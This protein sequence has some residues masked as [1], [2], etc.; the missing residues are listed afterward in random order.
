MGKRKGGEEI[1]NS[2]GEKGSR[3]QRRRTKEEEKE[4]D[5]EEEEKKRTVFAPCALSKRHEGIAVF[6]VLDGLLDHFQ[7]GFGR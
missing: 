4:E 5:E 6:Q 3:R 2:N 1:E 7:L